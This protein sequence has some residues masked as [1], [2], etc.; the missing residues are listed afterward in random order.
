MIIEYK[1][2]GWI[3][4]YPEARVLFYLIDLILISLILSAAL[5][6]LLARLFRSLENSL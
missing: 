1:T 6:I 5:P 4:A 3:I 2:P